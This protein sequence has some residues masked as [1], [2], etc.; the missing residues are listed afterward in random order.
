MEIHPSTNSNYASVDPNISKRIPQLG[1]I[2]HIGLYSFF[3]YDDIKSARRRRIQNGSEWY[4]ERLQERSYRPVSGSEN[5][6]R[7]H[8]KYGINYNYFNAP[9]SITRER[10]SEWM[11]ICVK[12]RA[13]Y[14]LITSRHHDGFC[15]W[16]TRTTNKKT[17]EDIVLIFKEEAEKRGIIFGIYYSWFEFTESMTLDYF[18]NTCIPQINELLVY[19]PKMIWFDG[20]WNIKQKALIEYIRSMVI[21]FKNNGIIINDRITDSNKDVASFYVGPDRFIP[22]QQMSN[23]QSIQSIGISWGYNREQEEVDYKSG[24][25]LFQLFNRIVELGG[26]LLLNIGPKHDGSL[27]EREARSLNDFALLLNS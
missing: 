15:L 21:Y 22:N 5:T 25:Q 24:R 2:F 6:Q 10:I 12:C 7:N 23:W 1:F 20:D 17:N 26:N 18:N 4:L 16:N 19:S 9:F 11:D 8:L 27:D 14:V 3:G 13:T